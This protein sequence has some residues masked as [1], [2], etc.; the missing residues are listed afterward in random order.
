MNDKWVASEYTNNS[1]MQ[2]KHAMDVMRHYKFVGNEVVL[3][4][5]CGDGKI[6][7]KIAELIPHGKIIGIDSSVSMI[8]YAKTNFLPK[9]NNLSFQLMNAE[10]FSFQ[11]SFD[12]VLS[13]SCLHWIKDQIKVWDCIKNSIKPNGTALIMFYKKHEYLWTSID[14]TILMPR[15]VNYFRNYISPFNLFS[16]EMY[17]DIIRS[18]GFKANR[19]EEIT[20]NEIFDNRMAVE[21]FLLTW[22][23]HVH[24]VPPELQRKFIEDICDGFFSFSPVAAGDSAEMP[25]IRIAAELHPMRDI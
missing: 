16:I 19:I 10:D 4:I 1:S 9:Y 5:G 17:N 14:R 3:D 11:E 15:W 6:S 7:A 21:N 13:F 22:V 25:F 18:V 20:S 23:P 8:N 2:F 24:Q 12:L